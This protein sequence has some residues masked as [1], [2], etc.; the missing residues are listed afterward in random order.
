MKSITYTSIN[1]PDLQVLGMSYSSED[2]YCSYLVGFRQFN[3]SLFPYSDCVKI[4]FV[5]PDHDQVN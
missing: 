4:I 5:Y 3:R 1:F 2:K